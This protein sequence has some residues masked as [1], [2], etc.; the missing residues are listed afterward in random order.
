MFCSFAHEKKERSDAGCSSS[1]DFPLRGINKVI[2]KLHFKG[3]TSSNLCC[4]ATLELALNLQT[5]KKSHKKQIFHLCYD[6]K[7]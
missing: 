7:V 2:F 5:L 6:I 4:V 3:V 1:C